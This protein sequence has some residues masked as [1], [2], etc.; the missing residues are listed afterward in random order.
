MPKKRTR[1]EQ[2]RIDDVRRQLRDQRYIRSENKRLLGMLEQHIKKLTR[3]I[4]AKGRVHSQHVRKF[5]ANNTR[6]EY[7]EE[8]LKCLIDTK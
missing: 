1:R 4:Q 2:D 3:E 8:R 6:I 7:L 5:N